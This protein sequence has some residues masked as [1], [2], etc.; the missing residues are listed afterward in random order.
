MKIIALIATLFYVA[1]AT[2]H[3]YVSYRSPFPGLAGITYVNGVAPV[4]LV[5]QPLPY[6]AV[7]HVIY[8]LDVIN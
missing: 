6:T 3:P 8:F 4:G 1:S 5:A 2:Q 7:H